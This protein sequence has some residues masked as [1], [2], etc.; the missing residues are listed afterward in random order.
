MQRVRD[1]GTLCPEWD[2]S[3]K[4]LPSGSR[5]PSRENVRKCKSQRGGVKKTRPSKSA[6]SKLLWSLRQHAQGLRG[7][8]P[9]PLSTY[10]SSSPACLW[11]SCVGLWF[12]CLLS[13]SFPSV[14]FSCPTPMWQFLFYLTISYLVTFYYYCPLEFCLFSNETEMGWI[15]L[16]EEVG[17]N[18]E[19]R[20]RGNHNQ[21]IFY[22]RKESIC[23]KR[24]KWKK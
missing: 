10:Q 20:R 18:W 5:N 14:G 2:V 8:A 17:R 11:E 13:G 23:N 19:S 12:L 3:T 24:K 6:E 4:S 7:S 22:V 15:W 16:G 9:G 1:L 21:D